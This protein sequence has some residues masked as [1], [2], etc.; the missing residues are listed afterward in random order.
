MALFN[1]RFSFVKNEEEFVLH[2]LWKGR[3]SD[4]STVSLMIALQMA[5]DL[6]A[7]S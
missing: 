4:R 6:F 1:K 2:N 5:D 7:E 3:Y